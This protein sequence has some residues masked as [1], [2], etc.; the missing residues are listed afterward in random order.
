MIHHKCVECYA[1]RGGSALGL[2]GVLYAPSARKLMNTKMDFELVDLAVDGSNTLVVLVSRLD[3][4]DMIAM[5]VTGVR[6][7][8]ALVQLARSGILCPSFEREL[9]ELQ[10][11][12]D[13]QRVLAFEK[14]LER[15]E[16]RK[17]RRFS[18][19][20][21]WPTKQGH[22]SNSTSIHLA[23]FTLIVIEF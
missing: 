3:E 21:E 8:Y 23:F 9:H 10:N 4:A 2:A 15:F 16:T 18:A 19:C 12:L 14:L 22:P 17:Q 7:I 6:R 13:F 5:D 1:S 11:K 20:S